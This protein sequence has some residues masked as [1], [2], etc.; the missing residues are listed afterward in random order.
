MVEEEEGQIGE[1]EEVEV[2]LPSE[3]YSILVNSL[4]EP[5]RIENLVSLSSA[6]S[7]VGTVGVD[8]LLMDPVLDTGGKATTTGVAKKST[9][10]VAKKSTSVAKKST[11]GGL[12][13]SSRKSLE[14]RPFPCPF[15]D[16]GY[17]CRSSLESHVRPLTRFPF[18]FTCYPLK[19]V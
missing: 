19:Y 7:A 6:A 16:K 3:G 12:R 15:C 4:D 10:G 1:E 14:E 9:T 17:K 2:V 5:I 18:P 13:K 11:G 8:P